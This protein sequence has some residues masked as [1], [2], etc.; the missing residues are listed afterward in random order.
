MS[1]E[2]KNQNDQDLDLDLDL[3][4]DDLLLKGADAVD[5]VE[6]NSVE[7]QALEA[8]DVEVVKDGSETLAEEDL[9][10]EFDNYVADEY[11]VNGN[12][13]KKKKKMSKKKKI[14]LFTSLAVVG[15]IVVSLL[16]FVLSMF[17][18]PAPVQ[19]L[20]AVDVNVDMGDQYYVGTKGEID[21]TLVFPECTEFKGKGVSGNI[22]KVSG[23]DPFELK[24]NDKEGKEIL[25]QVTVVDGGINVSDWE[26]LM[27]VTQDGDIAVLQNAVIAPP[28]LEGEKRKNWPTINVYNDVYGNGCVLNVF[29]YVVCRGKASNKIFGAP[30][31]EGNGK[32]GGQEGIRICPREDGKEILFQDVHI[33][34][35]DMNQEEGGNMFGLDDKT[36]EKRGILLFSKYGTLLNVLGSQENVALKS[37]ANVKHCIVENGHKVFHVQNAELRIEG[38]IIQNA[39][40]TALSVATFAN[41]GSYIKSKNNVIAN[42]LTGGV[43]FYCFDAGINAGNAEKTWNTLEIEKGSFL[44]IYNWK[45]QNGLAFLPETEGAADIANPIAGSEI[46]K[47]EYD[48]LKA[49]VDSEKFIHF[50]IIKI[51]TGN[52][53]P[54]NGSKVIGYKELGFSTSRE[55]GF[56]KGFPIPGIA[57]MIMKEIEV[58]GYYGND[59]GDVGPTSKI[60][61]DDGSQLQQLYDELKNGRKRA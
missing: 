32:N 22:L 37:K 2:L 11:D 55:N 49:S 36:K 45:N 25:K 7:E 19:S 38:T 5:A 20:D 51:R 24:F 43:L 26:G 9:A 39:S 29:E 56:D 21:L 59:K 58:W 12:K 41:Q 46:P 60:G 23:K 13:I 53:L 42:S 52:G 44:D 28:P 48:S 54:Q 27:D 33:T 15:V 14:I 16:G 8:D 4:D 34:G 35:N 10:V 17:L 50:A 61:G 6:E 57:Q 3:T 40:D 30:V 31:L 1:D 18:K 47:K